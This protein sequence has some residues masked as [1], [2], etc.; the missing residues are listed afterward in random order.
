MAFGIRGLLRGGEAEEVFPHT[1]G[2]A[3]VLHIADKI[4]PEAQN[5]ALAVT[6]DE[7]ND[8]VVLDL[9]AELPNTSWEAIAAALPRR[10][11]GIRLMACGQHRGK[12]AMVGQWLS[13]RLNRRVIAPDGVLVRGAGGALFVD[14]VSGGGWV[15]FRRG[16]PPVLVGKRYPSPPWDNAVTEIRAS[17]ATGEIEPLPGGVWIR[18]TVDLATIAHYRN[19]LVADVPCTDET[20]T[21]LVGCPRTPT[22][23]I[24]DVIRFW[25]DLDPEIRARAR[26]VQYGAVQLRAGLSFGQTLADVLETTVICYSGV[27][28]GSPQ[29]YTI[30]AVCADG[31][32]G[33]EPF[34]L[35]LRF[36][37][38][39]P[40]I[41]AGRPKVV[42][43]RPPIEGTEEINDRV[44]WYAP[45][46]VVEVVQAGL[47]VRPPTLPAGASKVR[48][49][50][51]DAETAA[52]FFDDTAAAART[53][54][55]RELASD[56]AARLDIGARDFGVVIASSKAIQFGRGRTAEAAPGR[57]GGELS[58]NAPMTMRILRGDGSTPIQFVAADS[59]EPSGAPG[60][61][62]DSALV[63]AGYAPGSIEADPPEFSAL[64]SASAEHPIVRVLPTRSVAPAVPAVTDV[65]VLLDL[66]GVAAATDVPAVP[67]PPLSTALRTDLSGPPSAT[68][69]SSPLPAPAT[70]M[71]DPGDS[72]ETVP[73]RAF[74]EPAGPL[75]ARTITLELMAVSEQEPPAPT[76]EQ[77]I[78]KFVLQPVPDSE[79]SALIA[80]EQRLD[81]EREWLRH[82]L[83][84]DYAELARPVSRIFAEH[85]GLKGDHSVSAE[86]ALVDATVVRLFLGG[87]GPVVNSGLRSAIIGPHVPFGRCM[88]AGMSRLP[89]FRG[90]TI[91]RTT[92]APA[93]WDLY[94]D[95]PA[96]PDWGFVTALAAPCEAQEGDTDV[97]I[98]SLT[99]RR[100]GPLEPDGPYHVQDRVLFAAGTSFKVLELRE[101]APGRRGA[102]LLRELG[103]K[104]FSEDGMLS[105]DWL[106]FDE[107]ALTSLHRSLEKWATAQPRRRIG[108]AAM[109]RFE[110]LPGLSRQG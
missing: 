55:M 40:G 27:P 41:E 54:R 110:P 36:T 97:A 93:E 18:P 51:V 35:E 90:A 38:N 105:P 4:S 25:R 53:Q 46:A 26:F 39:R 100:T 74:A 59:P 47:W 12:A 28:V 91:Y 42:R 21:V 24:D 89:S 10:R 95:H 64:S 68:F 84:K 70:A 15:Q 71:P 60:T 49:A 82:T 58:E 67:A 17:S 61:T 98:W 11:R 1:V 72:L 69:R 30:K 14:S 62:P 48:A 101:P 9:G 104:E 20:M 44:Y 92:P 75:R 50:G 83:G 23:H 85:P 103:A 76:A 52:L 6:A 79:S 33:W 102:I 34:A 16:K 96:F 106:S 81:D 65:P 86:D 8:I 63:G 57:P 73:A 87:P 29:R 7:D 5:L 32:L 88:L 45:D 22:L 109:D 31:E 108:P 78:G 37:P 43:H 80:P 13:Q 19:R 56:L 77:P 99:G 107:L 2:N 3:L 94:R 66:P